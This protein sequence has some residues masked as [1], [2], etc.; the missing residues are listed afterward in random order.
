GPP[1]RGTATQFP[2][3]SRPRHRDRRLHA[4]ADRGQAVG[5]PQGGEA[6]LG[7][8]VP[9]DA[10]GAG[11]VQAVQHVHQLPAVLRRLPGLRARSEVHRPG[12]HRLGPALQPRLPRRG[13]GGA[14]GGPLRA[15]GDL[16]LHLRG[17]V[18][19]SVSQARRSRR[20]H[21][22]LQA[23]GGAGVAQGLLPAAGGAMS[24]QPGY[25]EY[26]PRWYRPRVSTWWWLQRGPYLSFILREVSSLFVAWSVVYLLL[27]IHAVSQGEASY[28][29]FLSWSASPGI[30]RLNLVSLFFV[31]FHAITWFN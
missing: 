20:R 22:A 29:Q 27:L 25:T 15:R 14:A 23:E 21:P 30:V 12:G 1:A 9:A 18:Y 24:E 17:R 10:G 31:V 8:R 16:G 6:A 4:E 13:R 26:H 28:Q 7:R 11:R 19:P 3:R 5:R 2:G